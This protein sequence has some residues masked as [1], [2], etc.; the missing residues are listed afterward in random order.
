MLSADRG[1][2]EWD[3]YA[4]AFGHRLVTVRKARGLS[5]EELAERCGLHRN[6]VSNLE[7]ATSNSASGIAD[8]LMSTVYRL[9]RALDVPPTY[10]MPGADTRPGMRAAEQETNH[11]LSDVEAELLRLLAD[12]FAQ[13][14]ETTP[15]R[16][17]E[18]RPDDF[19]GRRY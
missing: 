18:P 4:F 5:Q 7:R 10:L 2:L 1:S 12:E 3:T 19:P 9:A 13:S 17:D 11:A 15:D 8:P 6:A 16:P 14:D